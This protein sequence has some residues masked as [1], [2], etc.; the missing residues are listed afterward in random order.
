MKRK[1]KEWKKIQNKEKLMNKL[2]SNFFK[3]AV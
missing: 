1:E 3:A 2:E